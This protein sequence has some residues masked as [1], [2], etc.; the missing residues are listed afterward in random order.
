[1]LFCPPGIIAQWF[2][3]MIAM[4]ISPAPST[5]DMF[6]SHAANMP[7]D[8]PLF[9]TES[10]HNRTGR[11]LRANAAGDAPLCRAITDPSQ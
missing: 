10:L 3:T 2:V 1:M 6:L 8:S 9:H 4:A 5:T 11:R 7:S